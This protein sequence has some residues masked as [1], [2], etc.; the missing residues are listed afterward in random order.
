MSIYVTELC[1]R[2]INTAFVSSNCGY[3]PIYLKIRSNILN[4]GSQCVDVPNT[5]LQFS[6]EY[7]WSLSYASCH[8]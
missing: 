7:Q 5:Y 1:L 8:G 4:V 3:K 2:G 6:L